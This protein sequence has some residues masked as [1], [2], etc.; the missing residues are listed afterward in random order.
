MANPIDRLVIE[1][2]LDSDELRAGLQQ[3]TQSIAD[4]GKRVTASGDDI[5]RLA[6]TASSSGIVVKGVS[7]EVAERI[8]E[9][10]TAGQ[11]TAVTISRAMDGMAGALGKVSQIAGRVLAPFVAAFAGGNILANL[12]Q[13][14]EELSILSERTGVAVD[15]IDAWAKANRDA[16]GS[17]EAFRSALENWT[18]EQGRSADDFFRMGEAVKGMSQQQAAYFM[19]AMGLSQDAAAI[20]TKY[21]DKA[22]E[23]AKAYA[24]SVMTPE[25]AKAAREMNILW[26]RFTDQAQSLGNMLAVTVLPVVNKVLEIFGKVIAVLRGNE[27]FVKA[28]FVGIAAILAGSVLRSAVQAAGGFAALFKAIKSGTAITAAFNAV[29]AANPVGFVITAFVALLAILEDF[30]TFLKG[31]DSLFG[32]FLN[33]LGIP[34]KYI[35][36]WRK[37]VNKFLGAI[38]SIPGSIIDAIGNVWDSI[39]AFGSWLAD[40]G[41]T[42]ANIPALLASALS[43]AIDALADLGGAIRDGIINGISAAID[44]AIEAFKALVDQVS[45]WIS[46]ALDIGGKVKGALGSIGDFFGFGDDGDNKTDGGAVQK[47]IPFAQKDDEDQRLISPI[48]Q[49]SRQIGSLLREIAKEAVP[50]SAKIFPEQT[51]A[52]GIAAAQAVAAGAGVSNDMKI[53]VVNNIQTQDD[54]QAVGQA[55]GGAMDNALSR[56]NRM[57]VAAQSGVISK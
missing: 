19:R 5:D 17:E 47:L 29:M 22:Q 11:K 57:L 56:R 4:F 46:S 55:V 12:S 15:K 52:G 8:Y 42:I 35:D 23:A 37:S 10:G 34:Q 36:G 41:K 26:R 44:W 18:V 33:W 30:Y 53:S 54:P 38:A 39:K 24:G 40:L 27:R 31:G 28:L 9:I 2:G 45:G 16:G 50:S 48:L 32:R 3:A 49:E 20:F 7:D 13:M 1:L 25:Q 21:T 51:A 14:G 6:A 43:A